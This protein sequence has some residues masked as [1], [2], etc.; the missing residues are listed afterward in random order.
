M[1]DDWD[2]EEWTKFDNFMV[3]ALQ[4]YLKKGL[5][6]PKSINIDFNRLKIET[7]VDFIDFMDN[8]ISMPEQYQKPE[9]PNLLVIDKNKY[10]YRKRVFGD[11]KWHQH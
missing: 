2:E 6:E 11:Q 7:S 4:Y 1:F 10:L 3:V 8:L 9:S 5:L